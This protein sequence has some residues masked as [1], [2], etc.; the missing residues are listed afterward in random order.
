MKCSNRSSRNKRQEKGLSEIRNG[1]FRKP[2]LGFRE[3][4]LDK[5]GKIEYTA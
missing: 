4:S 2:F 1:Y 3:K 5:Q